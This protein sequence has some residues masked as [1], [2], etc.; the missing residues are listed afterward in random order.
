MAATI[1][2]A[3]VTDGPTHHE[4]AAQRA[5]APLPSRGTPR[6]RLLSLDVFRGL[7]VAG[8]LLVN[9]PGSWSAIY[10]P[11]QHAAWHGWTPTDLIFPFFLFI[12]GITTHLSM[13]ARRER[14]EED[15]ALVR[16][17]VRR[18]ALIVLFGLLLAAFPFVPL[19]RVTGMRFPGV[20]QRIGVA[21]L[22]GALLTL[23]SS[24]KQQLVLLAVLLFGYWFA[25]TLIPV[26]GRGIGA[27]LLDDPSASLAAWI[28]R[29]VFGAHLWRNSVTW[30][31]EGLLSTVPAI[32][33]V[34][35][36]VMA[37]RWIGAPRSLHER[38]VV[39]Y[40][41]GSLC[42]VAG[43]MWHWSF[44]INKSLWTSSYVLFTGGT[45]AV[46]LATC[47]WLIDV[48]GLTW[49][50]KPFVWYGM[51]PMVAF[52]GSGMMARMIYSIVKVPRNGEAVPIQ[53]VIF[54]DYFASWLEPRNASLLFA[55]TVVLLWAG[56]LGLL[57]RK[58]IFF[59]V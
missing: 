11:L 49:W 6:E 26:P 51:N 50:T 12:V 56:I 13:Q 9:N 37:G 32:G 22:F 34:I 59:K 43:L 38:L 40:G 1:P 20:L 42:M 33:T 29:A 15:A 8:M 21:Y 55:V 54:E 5:G 47:I 30:D 16:Q 39:L 3:P 31:P 25:M 41:V 35:L 52:V 17:I 44:P 28:D 45:A 2:P 10:P 46:S 36:G 57:Y 58:R 14:G 27:L 23:R 18:G 48:L 19:D 53:R 24:V 4:A 7:T